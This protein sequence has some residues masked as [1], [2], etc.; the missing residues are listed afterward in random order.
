MIH[1]L[2]PTD[3]LGDVEAC[4]FV[5]V[6]GL[7]FRFQLHVIP[8]PALFPSNAPSRLRLTLRDRP[9]YYLLP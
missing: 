3:F 4:V 5:P 1:D 6:V 9:R 2:E 7:T 8:C